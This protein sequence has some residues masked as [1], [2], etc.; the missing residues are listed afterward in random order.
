MTVRRGEVYLTALP[1]QAKSRP[2][3]VLTADWLSVYAL[4]VTVVPVTS[5]AR[6]RFPTRVELPAGE[7][8]LKVRSWAKCD[9][10]TTIAKDLLTGR[11]FGRVGAETMQAIEDAVRMALGL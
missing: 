5:V 3:I 7:G 9:Q 2:V 10:V 6:A 4:D 8:G 1:N 11:S